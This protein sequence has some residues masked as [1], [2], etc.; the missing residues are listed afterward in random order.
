M[1]NTKRIILAGAF[2]VS[3][4]ASICANAW[5]FEIAPYIWGAGI[6]GELDINDNQIDVSAEFS[7]ILEQTKIAGMLM[8]E[9]NDGNWVNFAQIDYLALEDNDVQTLAI[10]RDA[11][12][13]VDTLLAAFTT[14]YRFEAGAGHYVDVMVGVRYAGIDTELDTRL[15]GKASSN[16]DIYD[17]ILM[18]RP[19]VVLNDNWYLM[20][21][22]S[23]GGGDSDLTWEVFPELIYQPGKLRFRFGYRNLNYE[24]EKNGNEIDISFRGPLIGVGFVF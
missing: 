17:A 16:R 11:H 7:D 3:M 13:E 15:R 23:V 9:A 6:D 8:L 1:C 10:T 2:A 24:N 18:I 12:L 14:G 4:S 20:P 21:S 19:K 5:E 22:F